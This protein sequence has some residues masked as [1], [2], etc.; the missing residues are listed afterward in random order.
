MPKYR[1][2][3]SDHMRSET[4]GFYV[5]RYSVLQAKEINFHI[6]IQ[7]NSL[8]ELHECIKFN[9]M[10]VT[11][12]LLCQL[13]LKAIVEQCFVLFSEIS[14]KKCQSSCVIGLSICC[15]QSIDLAQDPESP[16]LL[17]GQWGRAGDGYWVS[18]HPWRLNGELLSRGSSS[19]DFP[20]ICYWITSIGTVTRRKISLLGTEISG[21]FIGFDLAGKLYSLLR[22]LFLFLLPN[23]RSMLAWVERSL[24]TLL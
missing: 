19:S 16:P 20:A 12:D 21:E 10:D 24:H 1:E 11:G 17:F 22:N 14:S 8:I 13:I 2:I 6:S 7:E 4:F 18:G 5:R 15:V 9:L 3:K 23:P